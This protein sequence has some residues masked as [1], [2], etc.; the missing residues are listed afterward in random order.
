M[1]KKSITLC[2]KQNCFPKRKTVNVSKKAS[3]FLDSVEEHV[4]IFHA[5]LRILN[6][7]ARVMTSLANNIP[8]IIL[9][10][11]AAVMELL[12]R[13]NDVKSHLVVLTARR[14][15]SSQHDRRRELARVFR[16]VSWEIRYI[17]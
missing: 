15:C 4:K 17:Q 6:T 16:H 13:C 3:I 8:E 7:K 1:Q 14:L 2:S 12:E 9:G 5:I 11:L 10:Y